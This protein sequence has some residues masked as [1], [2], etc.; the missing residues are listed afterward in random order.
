MIT[1]KRVETTKILLKFLNFFFFFF[2]NG[3]P[4]L[5]ICLREVV[6]SELFL[7]GNGT[8]K[9]FHLWQTFQQACKHF[10]L[11][12]IKKRKKTDQK[13]A[14][15][16]MKTNLHQCRGIYKTEIFFKPTITYKEPPGSEGSFVGRD[17]FFQKLKHKL[18][19]AGL[20]R[21]GG[22]PFQGWERKRCGAGPKKNK[23]TF[24]SLLLGSVSIS[25]AGMILS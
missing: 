1:A 17:C 25:P 23:K 14:I 3:W 13:P 8:G 7:Y 5:E 15:L 19:T 10:P 18:F 6:L 11:V 16:S 12:E 2:L 20:L 21:S 4:I 9:A 22:D 24:A